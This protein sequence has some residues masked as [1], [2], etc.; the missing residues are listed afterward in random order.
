MHFKCTFE[1]SYLWGFS[2]NSK[3]QY[4]RL[5]LTCYH[6][7]IEILYIY[8]LHINNLVRKFIGYYDFSPKMI[9]Y[10]K[11]F[12]WNWHKGFIR[13]DIKQS[14]NQLCIFSCT[15]LAQWKWSMLYVNSLSCSCQERTHPQMQCPLLGAHQTWQS[16]C[17]PGEPR[18]K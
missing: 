10:L 5:L 6:R 8:I 13:D 18:R 16:T 15:P 9:L 3:C 1:P 7:I 11:A 2:R 4:V 17:I 14:K 12:I